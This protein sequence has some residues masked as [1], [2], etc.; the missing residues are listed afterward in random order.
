MLLFVRTGMTAA[1][2]DN[3]KIFGRWQSGMLEPFEASLAITRL[4]NQPSTDLNLGNYELLVEGD[5]DAP[6]IRWSGV[7]LEVNA[8]ALAWSEAQ[9]L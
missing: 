7:K 2:A 9:A 8:Q 3:P 4:L 5:V 6:G 1:Y